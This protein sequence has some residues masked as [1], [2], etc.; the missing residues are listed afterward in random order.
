MCLPLL[1]Q[2]FIAEFLLARGAENMRMAAL[3]FVGYALGDIVK[4]ELT[5]FLGDTCVKHDV[6]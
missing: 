5:L 6:E 2:G 4:I 3:H 1:R